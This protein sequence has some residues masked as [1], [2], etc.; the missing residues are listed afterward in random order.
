MKLFFMAVPAIAFL[1]IAGTP[2][3]SLAGDY[4]DGEKAWEAGNDAEAVRL[5]IRA[6]ERGGAEAQASLGAIY[7]RGRRAKKDFSASAYWYEKA[8][9]QGNPVSQ[10][11][12]AS[13]YFAGKGV[14]QDYKEAARWVLA[15]AKLGLADA[16][17]EI[18][19][20]LRE[21][22]GV[23]HDMDAA[24]KWFRLAAA[25]GHVRAK[26]IVAALGPK[27][28][29]AAGTRNRYSLIDTLRNNAASGSLTSQISLGYRYQD[30]RGVRKD[31][32]KAAKWFRMAAEQGNAEAQYRYGLL[33]KTGDGV[34]QNHGAA[35]KWF[36]LA[37]EQGVVGAQVNLALNYFTGKGVAKDPVVAY[38]WISVA[39]GLGFERL[40]ESRILIAPDLSGAQ[41]VEA[42]KLANA[43][44]A[45]HKNRKK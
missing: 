17:F 19:R 20:T 22:R 25:Q 43:W 29:D 45:R 27:P 44:L 23:P 24:N 12:L 15:A 13:M 9:A 3:A 30:G 18:G 5:Y 7:Y 37:A 40:Q 8:A 21:G 36:R 11:I 2:A 41:I 28:K 42:E 14:A 34:R 6:A 38:K 31:L 4:E 16:Q 10:Y 35:A 1:L 33:I 39:G 26:K 32:S